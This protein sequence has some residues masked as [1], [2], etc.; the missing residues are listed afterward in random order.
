MHCSIKI[1]VDASIDGDVRFAGKQLRTCTLS[2]HGSF[3]KDDVWC[4]FPCTRED[5]HP[6]Y[7]KH[8]YDRHGLR[9][10]FSISEDDGGVWMA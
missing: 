9:V 5:E 3:K 7:G 2:K 10:E 1:I 6:A 8:W 4:E